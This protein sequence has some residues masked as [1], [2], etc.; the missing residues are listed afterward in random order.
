MARVCLGPCGMKLAASANG[1]ESGRLDGYDLPLMATAEEFFAIDLRVGTVT[2]AEPFPEARKPSIRL[3][4][5]FGTGARRAAVERSAHS[6]LHAGVARRAAGH[7]RRQS[8]RPAD[9]GVREPGARAR[10]HAHAHEVVLLEVEHPVENGTRI[11]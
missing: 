10:R 4:I 11:G 9:R 1:V 6:S 2:R 3:W 5:D 8:R 7:R